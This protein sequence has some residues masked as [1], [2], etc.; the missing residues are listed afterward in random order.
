MGLRKITFDGAQVASK[1]DA[2]INYHLFNLIPAGIIKGLGQEV[3]VSAGN[4]TINFASGYVQIYGRRIYVES[5]TSMAITLDSNK[6][7]YVVI[8]VNLATNTL[9]LNKLESDGGY[10]SLIQ[11]NL[12]NSAG[13]YQFPIARYTKTPTSLTLDTA[14]NASRP[15]IKTLSN[16]V[17]EKNQGVYDYI[18][19]KYSHKIIRPVSFG[20]HI[21][22]YNISDF[23]SPMSENLIHVRM[24]RLGV[25]TFSGLHLTSASIQSLYYTW[26]GNVTYFLTIEYT[27]TQMYVYSSSTDQAHRI[28]QV[29]VFR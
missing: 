27:A 2:D 28:T 7:G 16:L 15:I 14:Y 8:D 25:F 10:P 24:G 11:N 17:D 1:D 3:A 19:N 6:Y 9:A 13:R 21:M 26:V 4:N 20:E 12:H 22:K 29:E 5:G 23:P 18:D